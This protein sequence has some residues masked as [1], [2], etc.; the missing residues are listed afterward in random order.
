MD[1]AWSIFLTQSEIYFLAVPVCPEA[2][3]YPTDSLQ[4]IH[5]FQNP[6]QVLFGKCV[7]FPGPSVQRVAIGYMS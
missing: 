2:L 5:A 4:G 3:Q 6:S 1:F 7:C